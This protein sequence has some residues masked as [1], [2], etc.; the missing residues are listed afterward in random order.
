[1]TELRIGYI[2]LTDAAPLIVAAELGFAEAEGL[3]L[4][5]ER[6]ASWSSIR[7]KLAVG[8]IDGAH[9]L[10]PLAI[11]SSL[12]LGRQLRTPLA[13]PFALNLNGN[14]VTA[15]LPLWRAMEAAGAAGDIASAAASLGAVARRR[16]AEGAPPL[17]F[18]TVF[19]FSVHTYQLRLL[20]QRAG[21]DAAQDVRLA[22]VPPPYMVEAL[23]SGAI[24]GFC[25]GSPWN[26]V[27]VDAGV[28]R[29]VALGTDLEPGCPEKLL[30]VHA[31]LVEESADAAARLVRALQAGG[32]WC[33]DPANHGRLSD[34][35][36]EPRHLDLSP[37]VILRTLR[38]RLLLGR[39]GPER[40]SP[41]YLRFGG[42]AHRPE[43]AHLRWLMDRMIEAGQLRGSAQACRDA[44]AVYRP[45]LYDAALSVDAHGA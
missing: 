22:V 27:A 45:D 35:L 7:D 28:G 43:P 23:R 11:A 16:R 8:L 4:V 36:G 41:G 14:A 26:S 40:A 17:A 24:D 31:R 1:M 33:A 37:A 42:R 32:D 19:P 34:L 15:S 39:N 2:P 9:I 30:A 6:E 25:V 5:L 38:G 18:A 21:L 13:A 10:A 12:G 29:I 20:L 44:Q 3:R